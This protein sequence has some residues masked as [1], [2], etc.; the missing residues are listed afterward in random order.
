MPQTSCDTCENTPSTRA[1]GDRSRLTR[2]AVHHG[3]AYGRRPVTRSPVAVEA[4]A[5][6]AR[7]VTG[8]DP[9]AYAGD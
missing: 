7:N 4:T 6:A 1:D 9:V 2:A 8:A 3:S 5:S